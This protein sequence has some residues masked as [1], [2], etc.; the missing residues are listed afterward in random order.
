LADS[1]KGEKKGGIR[2]RRKDASIKSFFLLLKAFPTPGGEKEKK[3]GRKRKY[4]REGK[5]SIKQRTSDLSK[6]LNH[7]LPIVS[8]GV[9]TAI[10]KGKEKKGN[11]EKKG[12]GGRE[13]FEDLTRLLFSYTHL[14]D[15]LEPKKKN[16]MVEKERE[17]RG[18]YCNRS[19]QTLLEQVEGS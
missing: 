10:P 19:M 5:G 2:R 17:R 15:Q 7:S 4:T 6:A 16:T 18:F 9:S 1:T 12:E 13:S 3:G 11:V 8:G 14:F